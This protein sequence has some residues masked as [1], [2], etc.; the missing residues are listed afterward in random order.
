MVD[1][2]QLLK[3]AQGMQKKM[4]EIQE[5][6]ANNEYMGK[7]GGGLI[8]VK[9]SGCGKMREIEIDNSLLTPDEKDILQDLIVAAFNDAKQKSDQDSQNSASGALGKMGLPAGFKMPF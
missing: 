5:Q 2:N 4:Q 9:I 7:S 3:Q 1:F 6:M 8:N